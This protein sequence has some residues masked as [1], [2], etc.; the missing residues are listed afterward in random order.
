LCSSSAHSFSTCFPYRFSVFRAR[1]RA[2]GPVA[3]PRRLALVPRTSLLS[4]LR[5]RALWLARRLNL[6]YVM[7]GVS[8]RERYETSGAASSEPATRSAR[9]NARRRCACSRQSRLGCR[10]PPRPGRRAWGSG[11]M[12]LPAATK[13]SKLDLAALSLHPTQ[14]RTGKLP[15]GRCLECAVIP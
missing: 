8:V 5:R 1:L 11:T 6:G 15:G 2:L 14:V 12:S 13:R 7:P 9:E 4:P 3:F 10:Y